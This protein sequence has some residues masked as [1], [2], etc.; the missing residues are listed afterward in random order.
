MNSRCGNKVPKSLA[1]IIYRRDKYNLVLDRDHNAS[2]N[3]LKKGLKIFN[4]SAKMTII[5]YRRN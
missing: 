2:I 4:L 1:M 5:N 3:I